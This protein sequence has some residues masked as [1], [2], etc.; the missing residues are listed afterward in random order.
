[1]I[2]FVGQ[3][4]AQDSRVLDDDG[5]ARWVYHQLHVPGPAADRVY[6]LKSTLI[7]SGPRYWRVEWALSDREF[8]GLDRA[9]GIRP[10]QLSG[11]WEIEPAVATG[12]ARARYALRIDP[13]G[14][15]P[16]WLARRM[17]DRY[18]QQVVAAF[19]RRLGE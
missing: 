16:A 8:P 19:R 5:V 12:G 3:R 2:E 6:V 13:G 14:L 4:Y 15:V 11:F 7:A 18:V 10:R 9:A 1:M 17:T